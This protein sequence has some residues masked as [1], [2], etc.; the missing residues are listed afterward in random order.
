MLDEGAAISGT[1]TVLIV[2]SSEENL[3]EIG[4]LIE[5]LDHAPAQLLIQVEQGGTRQGQRSGIGVGGD[6]ETHQAE[7]RI[8]STR[9]EETDRIGQQLRV[10]E[11]QWA[12]IRTGQA[13]PQVVQRRRPAR[14][15]VEQRIEYREV[16]SGFEVRPRLNGE[17]VTLDIRPFRANLA[18]SGGG[19]IEQ[20]EIITT[21]S[22]RLGEWLE[23]GGGTARREQDNRG[24][25]Y[26]TAERDQQS[27]SV[28]LKVERIT[29]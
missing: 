25:V 9:R 23:I 16:T 19:V 14:G 29:D 13:V 7:A 8:Y 5:Q 17:R 27:R 24:T 6:S 3:A 11:G 10:M 28:R 12:T 22:G 4:K 20:Q 15:Q 26:A 2:R 18:P 21:V 1:G